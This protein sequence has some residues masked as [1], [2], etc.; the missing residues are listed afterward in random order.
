MG[1]VRD[2]RHSI[3]FDR[4]GIGRS[5]RLGAWAGA[6]LLGRSRYWAGETGEDIYR[7]NRPDSCRPLLSI[8]AQTFLLRL[9]T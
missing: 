3:G 7:R 9:S 1:M 4:Y 6:G 5:H 8:T 2:V